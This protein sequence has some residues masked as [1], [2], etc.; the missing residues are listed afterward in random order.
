MKRKVSKVGEIT[1]INEQAMPVQSY[2]DWNVSY[3]TNQGM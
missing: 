3:V 2:S 1:G